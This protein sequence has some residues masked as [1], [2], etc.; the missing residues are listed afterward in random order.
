MAEKA[1]F[2]VAKALSFKQKPY[3][4]TLSNNDVILYALGIG[5]SRDP[6]NKGELRYTYENAENFGA[7]P[8]NSLVVCHRGPFAEGDFDVPGIPPFN[9]MMLLHGEEQQIIHNE[10]KVDTKYIVQEKIVDL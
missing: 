7:F 10:L 3:E 1:E 9:P 2:D 8:T 4:V 5:F 6:M